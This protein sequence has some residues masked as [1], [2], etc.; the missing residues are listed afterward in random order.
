M[1]DIFCEDSY[2]TFYSDEGGWTVLQNR[3]DFGNPEDYFYKGWD[4]YENGFGEPTK[5]NLFGVLVLS[6]R[7]PIDHSN[8]FP[9]KEVFFLI[10][11]LCKAILHNL[12]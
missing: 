9:G 3:G 4:E 12:T 11:E 8:P 5:V 7:V 1:L 10:H 6:L 2:K